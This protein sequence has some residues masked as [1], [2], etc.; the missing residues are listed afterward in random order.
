MM[1]CRQLLV[2]AGLDKTDWGLRIVECE[3]TGGFSAADKTRAERQWPYDSL[4]AQ[5]V[6]DNRIGPATIRLIRLEKTVA[7]HALM[8]FDS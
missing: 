7:A 6:R 2:A 3:Y 1:S 5:L 4:F 8:S